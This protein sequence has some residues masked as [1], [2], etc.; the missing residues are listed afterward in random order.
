MPELPLDERP[1]PLS[2]NKGDR[3]RRHHLRPEPR[4]RGG[5]T[6]QDRRYEAAFAADIESPPRIIE[7]KAVGGS[8]RGWFLPL[9]APGQRGPDQSRLLR[10]TSSTNVR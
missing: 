7:V 3:G 8:Q 4:A 9:E 1:A 6:P 2:G 10:S 5:R